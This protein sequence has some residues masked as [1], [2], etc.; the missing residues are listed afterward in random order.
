MLILSKNAQ[1]MTSEMMVDQMLNEINFIIEI[2]LF[3]YYKIPP[4]AN[5][6]WFCISL[7]WLSLNLISKF[8][9]SGID[10]NYQ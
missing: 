10:K 6:I 4:S 5:P 1:D 3:N 7:I 8:E 2:I 9:F